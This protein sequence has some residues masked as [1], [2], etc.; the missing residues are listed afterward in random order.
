MKEVIHHYKVELIAL[1][2][3]V[4]SI[5]LLFAGAPILPPVDQASG[6]AAQR[7]TP[8]A[9]I[10]AVLV[11]GAGVFIVWRVRVRFLSSAHW[12]ATVCPRCGS[13]IHHAHR[14]L[15]EKAASKVFLPHARRYRC[16]Q[17]E[18]GW[19]GLRYSRRHGKMK[20]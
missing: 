14:S 20:N 12:S 3:A 18:C 11:V 15:L 5:C 19:S 10:G 16:A 1:G 9:L 8:V 2:V 6:G 7:L 4:V 17:A 13:P